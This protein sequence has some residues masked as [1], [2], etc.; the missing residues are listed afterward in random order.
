MIIVRSPL[1]ISL[2]GGGSD[3]PSFYSNDF[4]AVCS[5]AINKY[6]YVT[7]NNLS[8]YFP[9]RLRIAYSQ[10]ELTQ[11]A[12]SIKHPIV[13]EALTQLKIQGGIDVNVMS[14]IPA[15]TGLGSSS[16]FTVSLI[17]ALNAFQNRLVGKD[18]LAKEAC[19]LE[20][21]IL[22][23][24]IGKQDQYAAS[25]GGINLFKFHKSEQVSVEPIPMSKEREESLMSRLMVFY[26]RSP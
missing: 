12:K 7:V 4:G 2:A 14:D 10:T 19:R 3:L 22:K 6:V 5:I 13:R 24:P 25:F 15:G 23:E 20:L 26:P 21:D 9:H 17:H 18:Y 1:R 11:D 8:V 16:T